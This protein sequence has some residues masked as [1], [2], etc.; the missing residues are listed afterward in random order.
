M[1]EMQHVHFVGIGGAGMSGIAQVL[2]EMGCKVS[3][4]DLKESRNT[5]RLKGYGA[6]IKVGHRAENIGDADVVV[7][8]SAIPAKNPEVKFAQEE[9]IPILLRAEMLARL[10]DGKKNIAVAGTHG[11]TTTTSMIACMI[12]MSGLDP[13]YLIGGELNDIGGNAKYGKGEYLIAEADESDSSFLYLNPHIIVLT[14]I[15]A[16]H[17]DHYDSL[18]QIEE[19]FQQFIGRVPNDGSIVACGDYPNIKKLIGKLDKRF[20]TYGL[21]EN[22]DYCVKNMTFPSL[23]SSFDVFFKGKRLAKVSL[24][25]PG[26]HNVYNALAAFALGVSLDLPIKQIIEGLKSFSGVQRR[27]QLVGEVSDVTVVDDYAHHPTELKATLE[28]AKRGPW[29]RIVCIFQPHRFS[30]T[31]FLGN[32][33]R[34]AFESADVAIVTDIYAA[35][36]EPVPGITGKILVEAIL[37]NNPRKSVIYLPKK[38]DILDFLSTKLRQGDLVLT[39]GAGDI[40]T[41]GEGLLGILNLNQTKVNRD[42]LSG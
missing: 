7:I 29:K 12:D 24:S 14:N 42:G 22:N 20:V 21:S 15:E 35:G 28:A 31:K 33:F 3:G 39:A 4:S 17:L 8:S 18:D 36:E 26:V 27:F 11:K 32:D 9:E 34:D 10:C 16:D 41:I 25:V 6:E 37:Q 19:V 23:S 5:E 2:L 13:T 1:I 30:R 40:W 38:N